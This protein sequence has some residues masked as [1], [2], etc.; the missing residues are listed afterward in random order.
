MVCNIV[1]ADHQHGKLG[2]HCAR[3]R[4][5]CKILAA[6]VSARGDVLTTRVRRPVVQASVQQA[7]VWAAQLLLIDILKRTC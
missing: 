3:H 2:S 7:S 5:V 4:A 6:V 1:G